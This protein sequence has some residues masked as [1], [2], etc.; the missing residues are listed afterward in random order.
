LAQQ[1]QPQPAPP[2]LRSVS[3]SLAR[4]RHLIINIRILSYRDCTSFL[5]FVFLCATFIRLVSDFELVTKIP[6]SPDFDCYPT[7]GECDS[8]LLLSIGFFLTI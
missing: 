8:K 4:H 5:G 1:P 3:S 2:A 7:N 6:S